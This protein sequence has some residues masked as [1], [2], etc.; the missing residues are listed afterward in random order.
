MTR[1]IKI[2]FLSVFLLSPLLGPV[3][4]AQTIKAASCNGADVQA[5]INA[6]S[7]GGSVNVPAGSC[8]WSSGISFS[9]IQVIGAGKTSSGTVITSGTATI[10]KSASQLTRLSGFDF[11]GTDNHVTV[12]GSASARAYI[13]DNSYFY[14]TGTNFMTINAN[15]GL[16]FDNDFFMP[17]SSSGGPDVFALHPNE[18]WS[19]PTTF[20]AADTQGPFGGERNIYFENNTFTNILETAPDGDQGARIVIRYNT[21]TDSSIVFH[22]GAPNDTST[23]GT[24]EFEIYNNAFHRVTSSDD[25]NKWVWVRGGSGVIANNTFDSINTQDFGGKTDIRLGVGCP[26][27]YPVPHQIGQT[28]ATPQSPPPQP[29]LIFGNTGAGT[30]DS[31]WIAVNANDTGTGANTGCSDP[32]DFV[33]VNRDYYLSNKWSWT[34]FTYPHPLTKSLTAGTLPSPPTGLIINVR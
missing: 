20:G 25:M 7:P 10:T 31:S 13:I 27:G 8:S 19:Q 9:G 33:Q 15:G 14:S 32:Q 22:S 18:D 23:D 6:A 4:L 1:L 3:A 12:N 16:L 17:P 29:L 34:P 30:S 11:T 5:A 24:R 26:V 2:S 28:S 21:Y